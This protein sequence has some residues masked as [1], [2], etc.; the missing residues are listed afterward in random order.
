MASITRRA[1]AVLPWVAAVVLV[2]ER[3]V[4]VVAL[5][6]IDA[7][8]G[9]QLVALVGL[10]CATQVVLSAVPSSIPLTSKGCCPPIPGVHI[11]GVLSSHAALR[12]SW[13]RQPR[14]YPL[15]TPACPTVLRPVPFSP[16]PPAPLP[17]GHRSG[18][19]R[20]PD[21]W[22]GPVQRHGQGRQG[23]QGQDH[24]REL[25]A[26]HRRR[27][28]H[29]QLLRAGR[30]CHEAAGGLVG[31]VP[32]LSL[33]CPCRFPAAL[34]GGAACWV[35]L[36]S[37]QPVGFPLAWRGRGVLLS[38]WWTRG[39]LARF[40]GASAVRCFLDTPG[41]PDPLF[42]FSKSRQGS[43]PAGQLVGQARRRLAA[44]LLSPVPAPARGCG[45]TLRGVQERVP[46]PGC[47]M[48]QEA[49]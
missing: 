20:G 8:A 34:L 30:R 21:P 6:V 17:A 7:C 5:V 33:A 25:Q 43:S 1:V 31:P 2:G 29:R 37:W 9:V 48:G 41:F 14:T 39:M 28:A 18:T 38:S 3:G 4:R 27:R 40:S 11:P 46:C 26:G 16:S 35:H 22:L 23:S 10:P 13:W 15:S 36:S 19:G 47:G 42:L 32:S 44:A 24:L 45:G 49:T 12:S